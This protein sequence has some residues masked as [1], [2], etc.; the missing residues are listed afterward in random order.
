MWFTLVALVLYFTYTENS[1]Y[2][3]MVVDYCAFKKPVD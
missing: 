1:E 3:V 2:K